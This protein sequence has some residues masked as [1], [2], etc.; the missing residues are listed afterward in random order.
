M[1][2]KELSSVERKMLTFGADEVDLVRSGLEETMITAYNGIRDTLKRKYI[3]DLRTAAFVYAIE[4]IGSDSFAS[5]FFGDSFCSVFA[6][7]SNT[8]S[9]IPGATTSV[10]GRASGDSKPSLAFVWYR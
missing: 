9:V 10:S 4:K 8:R 2:G 3:K 5:S 1:T 7:F 6:I